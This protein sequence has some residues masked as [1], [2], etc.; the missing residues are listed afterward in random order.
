M[1]IVF[2]G[3]SI[4][5]GEVGVSYFDMVKEEYPEY[6]LV[7]L[8]KNGDTVESLYKRIKKMDFKG[9]DKV[10]LF[11][12][13]NDVFGKLN[14]AHKVLRAL[15]GQSATKDLN[16][17]ILSYKKLLELLYSM[18]KNI[19]IIP[20]LLLGEEINSDWNDKVREVEVEIE[21]LARNF[22]VTYLDVQKKMYDYLQDK[23]QGS[24]LPVSIRQISKDLLTLKTNE[25][26]DNAAKE[27][28]LFFTLD[29]VHLNTKGAHYVAREIIKEL[30]K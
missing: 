12:G 15:Q 18:N 17:F 20:P 9:Y 21:L 14:R 5:E 6:D 3:D 29:G 19:V 27:R 26:I 13:I 23:E 10:F 7:N 24:Y 11:I 4:T 22:D 1:K 2:L 30:D 25:D 28:G 16:T 8:G